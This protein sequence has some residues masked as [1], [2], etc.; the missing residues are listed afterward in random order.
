MTLLEQFAAALGPEDSG[1][2]Q[3]VRDFVEWYAPSPGEFAP[4]GGDDVGIRTYLMQRRLGGASTEELRTLLASLQRF[5]DWAARAGLLPSDHPFVEF[6]LTRPLLSRDQIRKRAEIFSGSPEERE[7]SRLRALNELAGQLNRSSDAQTALSAALETLLAVMSLQTAWAFLLLPAGRAVPDPSDIQYSLAAASGLPPGLEEN[8]RYHLSNRQLCHCQTLMANGQLKRAVNIVECTRLMRST[9][10][11]G[12][13][14]G[15]LFH[16][17]V[18]I[19]ASGHPLGI[20][21]LATQEW[22]FLTA[23]D[24]QLL[25]AVGEHVAVALERAS[26]YDLADEQ[27]SRLEHELQLARQVQVSLLPDRL[28]SI[29]GFGLAADWRSA[30]EMAGDFYDVFPLPDNRWGI[31]VADVSDKGAAAAMYMAMTRSLIRT[32]APAHARPAAALKDVNRQL[33]AHSSADMF[34]T[35]FYAVLEPDT[36]TLSYANAGQNPPLLRRALG[37]LQLLNRTGMALGLFAEIEISD[38]ALALE[39]GD[40][41]VVYTDG[42][43]DALN[44]QGEDYGLERLSALLGAAPTGSAES[45]LSA[46]LD[47]LEAFTGDVP[48]FDDVTLLVLAVDSGG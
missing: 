44:K 34:V 29:P 5:Y 23:A 21:N 37:D 12:D 25:S 35:V 16:A 42:L 9:R 22:Q 36:H 20:L 7:I 32:S 1:V 46:L 38:A 11:H 41:L 24:L 2:L 30:R 6:N 27:R 26:L 47:D 45:R 28:P 31:I 17:S 39:S 19:I 48:P 40:T 13:N 43:T 10:A 15:L 33:L 4:N 8:D 18:P 14:R 3:A